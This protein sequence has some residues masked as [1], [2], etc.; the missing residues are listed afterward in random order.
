MTP[1]AHHPPAPALHSHA[2]Q[3]NRHLLWA[4]EGRYPDLGGAEADEHAVWSDALSEPVI[5][6]PGAYRSV[7]VE[8]DVRRSLH[9]YSFFRSNFKTG[10]NALLW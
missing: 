6:V 8:L 10:H 9:S 7:C 5:N 4:S 3:H 2:S 1:C